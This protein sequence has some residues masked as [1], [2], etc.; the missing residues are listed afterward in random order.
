MWSKLL[1]VGFVAYP[2]VTHFLV[3]HERYELAGGYIMMLLG[4]LFLQQLGLRHIMMTIITGLA[5]LLLGYLFVQDVKFVIY[6]PSIIVPLVFGYYFGRTLLPGQKPFITVMVEL[7]RKT[8]LGDKEH[9]YTRHVTIGWV[10]L[11]VFLGLEALLLALFA[12]LETWSYVTNF[13]NYLLVA[14]FFIVEF[15]VR[16]KVLSHLQHDNFWVFITRIF[17]I[18][19]KQRF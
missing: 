8:V 9:L 14:I 12:S 2:F 6:T 3:V 1:T 13:L 15:F 16:R 4:L 5:S 19:S 10:V 7:M 18:Y 11:F 17:K